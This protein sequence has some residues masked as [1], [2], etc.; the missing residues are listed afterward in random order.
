[1]T[2]N[3]MN[4]YA[5]A[6]MALVRGEGAILWDE[7]GKDYLD[8]SSG[9]AVTLL[10]HNHPHLVETLCNAAKNP[11]HVSNV[12]HIR[13]QER[14]ATR[15][16][17]V[18]F[19]DKVF[20]GN[21]GAEALEGSFKL[22]RRYHFIKGNPQKWR[23]ITITGAF[24]GRTLAA[25][26]AAGNEKYLEGCGPAV[27]GFDQVAH[28]NLNQLRTAITDETAAILIEPVQGEG[29]VKVADT[30]YLQAIR[31]VADEFGLL[32]IYDEVQCG[33]G[34]TG[35]YWAHQHDGVAPDILA[36][37]KGLGGGFPVGCIIAPDEIAEA[38]SPGVHGT[39]FGGNPLAMAVGNAVL[40]IVL[41]PGFLDNVQSISDYLDKKLHGLLHAFP[42]K[43][44]GLRG[45]GLLRGIQFHPDIDARAL[46]G[47]LRK[48]GLLT[49]GASDN[50]I[51]L[52]PPLIIT[53]KE[54]DQAVD[55]LRRHL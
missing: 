29:G 7:A 46:V 33:N 10:G 45:R 15:L 17:A 37:A 54:I 32:V 26:A 8:F 6:D 47:D 28:G 34:R 23:I 16:C 48:D 42:K 21:S 44:S 19:G 2:D 41:A 36:S 27:P 40:D 5:R 38:F 20:F 9:I 49:V 53:Q 24:H 14:L 30:S 13:D 31:D 50:V 43:I 11:W 12:V 55:I 39:T 3:L 25:L 22:A 35:T 51:R 52:I 18:G 1:M 4:T